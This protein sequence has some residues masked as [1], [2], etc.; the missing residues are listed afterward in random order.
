[1]TGVRVRI[2]V[3]LSIGLVALGIS[4]GEAAAENPIGAHSMLQLDSPYSFMQS[5]FAQAA[6]MHASAIR[7]DVAPALVF[8]DPS[9]P[10]DFAGLDELMSLSQIYNLPVV[11]D[12]ITIPPQIAS[13]VR[14]TAPDQMARCGTDDISDY[15]SEIATI[16]A[17]ADP[18]ITDWEIWNEPD[19]GAFFTGTPLQYA[20][21][22]RAAHD[23]I[24]AIDPT[25]EVLLGGISGVWAQPWLSQVFAAAGPDAAQAFDVANIHERNQLDSLAGDVQSWTRFFAGYGFSGPLWVTEHGYPSDP[26]YQ[27]DASYTAGPESQASYLAASI[28][29]LIDAGASMVFVT[30]RDNLSGQYASEGLL[31]GDVLDP[32]VAD[33][34]PIEKPAFAA[35][36][37][38]SDCYALLGR[39]CPEAAP[40]ASPATVA[41]PATHLRTSRV[42]S[43]SVSDPGSAPLELGAVGLIGVGTGPVSIARDGC[44][45]TILEPNSVC[46]VSLRYAPVT[47]G[48]FS[49]T[50][51]VP[52]DAGMLSVFVTAVSPSVSSLT[53]PQLR[54][55]AFARTARAEGLGRHQQLLVTLSNPLNAPVHVSG[56]SVVGS[57]SSEFSLEPN[58]CKGVQLAPRGR[59]LVYVSFTPTRPG[60]G[61][62][63][64]QLRGDGTP[65][66]VPLQA[67][68]P[69]LVRGL[70]STG[71]GMCFAPGSGRRVRVVTDQPA[72]V[73]W[74]VG[75]ARGRAW[76]RAVAAGASDTAL[77][78]LSL[79]GHRGLPPGAYR[80]T[81]TPGNSHGTGAV[82]S[83]SVTVRR[84]GRCR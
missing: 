83:A 26:S 60:V 79:A 42:V 4:A 32:P 5:M 53:S 40:A 45:G 71:G 78:A 82:A 37:A 75:S 12:L 46:S 72:A 20:R 17:H 81:V 52:S 9:Q 56:G 41:V 35:V 44:A 23:A 16:V 58:D 24:K 68:G 49:T 61:D 38:M 31:G 8:S 65:L 77:I 33:P 67:Y 13:C 25:D 43:V 70:G 21:M 47:G 29:T 48:A 55:T 1:M 69:P 59:C 10:P 30:E 54:R 63:V 28:P 14:P 2:L 6:A 76:T 64:L 80:I 51:A 34:Q 22:L 39:D 7:L 3:L 18:V 27:Y 73:R 19:N 84:P 66:D 74:V 50:L 57:Q 15:Q 11:A 36:R 62:A